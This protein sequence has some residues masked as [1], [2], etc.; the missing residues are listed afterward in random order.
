MPLVGTGITE[1]PLAPTVVRDTGC[2]PCRH[3]GFP[4]TA[5]NGGNL[6]SHRRPIPNL[7]LNAPATGTRGAG[8]KVDDF[9]ISGASEQGV[10]DSR[11]AIGG[12]QRHK[13]AGVLRGGE[14]QCS[15][16]VGLGRPVRLTS[17][18]DG[19]AQFNQTL[20]ERLGHALPERLRFCLNQSIGCL[21]W[22]FSRHVRPQ[23]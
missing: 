1:P 21:Q 6:M 18:I 22:S 10:S 5:S 23:S 12:D 8:S 4:Q 19:V 9:A 14:D 16:Q 17:V 13:F 3:R 7:R 20:L 11:A 15:E 2:M